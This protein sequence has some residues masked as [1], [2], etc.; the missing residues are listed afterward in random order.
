[1][2]SGRARS[3]AAASRSIAVAIML[4]TLTACAHS[5]SSTRSNPPA[6]GVTGLGA[7]LAAWTNHHGSE[8]KTPEQQT[9][10]QQTPEQQTPEQQ[11]PEQAGVVY[12]SVL[13]DPAGRV[14]GYVVTMTARSLSQA[15]A[16]VRQ[17]LPADATASA[18]SA[19]E[20]IEGTKCEIVDFMSPTLH[21]LFGAEHGDAVMAVF[22]A[23]NA[24]AMDTD[25]ITRAVVVFPGP[26]FPRQC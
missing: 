25:R 17:D 3:R 22:Q 11:T 9:S 12:S 10:E 2:S 21:R 14:D 20:G 13:T 18:P 6:A 15:E 24:I 8:Q 4:L 16:L 26:L 23:E 5:G 1:M 7:P 19:V